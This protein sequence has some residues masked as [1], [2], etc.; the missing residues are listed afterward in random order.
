MKT[1]PGLLGK[2]K[3]L[4]EEGLSAYCWSGGYNVPPTTITHSVR[5]DILFIDEVIGAGEIAISDERATDPDPRELAKVAHDAYVGGKL[6]KKAGL[7]H[8]H[9]GEGPRRMQC[10]RD[11]L[12]P[13]VFQVKPEWLYATHVERSEELMRD[14]IELAGAGVSVDVDVVEGGLVKWLRYYLDHGGDPSCITASSDAGKTSPKKL[15]EEVCGAV[16]RRGLPLELMLT[17]VTSNPARILKLE[18]KGEL[19]A[20]KDADVVVMT[21]G[22]LDIVHVLARGRRVVADGTLCAR[23]AFAE[24]S[25]RQIEMVGEQATG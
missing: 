24:E 9:V 16:V 10:L 21:R 7:T 12:D 20:G 8:F 4:R 23:P 13:T 11:L 17:L 18:Q 25:D 14:A 19:A 1:M 6:S 15:Y 5:D 3:A 22:S 2:V